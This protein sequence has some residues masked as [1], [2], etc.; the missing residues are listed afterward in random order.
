[1]RRI[2]MW[3]GLLSLT[4]VLVLSQAIVHGDTPKQAFSRGQDLLKKADFDGALASFARA[5]RADRNN[6]RY[7][8]QYAL[9]RQIVAFRHR[10]DGEKDDARWE[11]LAKGL[12]AFYV[13]EGLYSE[14]L[15]LDERIHARVLVNQCYICEAG[16]PEVLGV[17]IEGVGAAGFCGDEHVHSE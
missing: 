7:F 14:A 16:L 6:R 15:A 4:V 2:L 8:Q 5:V 10:L 1:M 9:V 3:G 11:Y 17:F 13:S 12:H